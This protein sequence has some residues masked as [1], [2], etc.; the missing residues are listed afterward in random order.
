MVKLLTGTI[1]SQ[2][3]IAYTNGLMRTVFR[4]IF[5]YRGDELMAVRNGQYKAHYWTWSNSME[6]FQ[7]VSSA[8]ICQSCLYACCPTMYY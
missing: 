6:E 2:C 4:S 8:H 3:S 1:A 5:Y 7:H